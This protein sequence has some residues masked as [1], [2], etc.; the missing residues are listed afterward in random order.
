MRFRVTVDVSV[1]L[2]LDTAVDVSVAI[3]AIGVVVGVVVGAAASAGAAVGAGTGLGPSSWVGFEAWALG[4]A[5][6]PPARRVALD[7]VGELAEIDATHRVALD[8]GSVEG[9]ERPRSNDVLGSHTPMGIEK[10]D[11][12]RCQLGDR[13]QH[14]RQV[15]C[16]ASHPSSPLTNNDPRP[17]QVEVGAAMNEIAMAVTITS[18]S[19]KNR[20]P[21]VCRVAEPPESVAQAK[22]RLRH[23]IWS[24]RSLRPSTERRRMGLAIA[25]LVLRMVADA[26]AGTVA[27]YVATDAEP[28]TTPALDALRRRGSRVLLPVQLPDGDLG[29]GPFDG[30]ESLRAG[31][32][33]I[34][35]P[36]TRLGVVAALS[37][38]VVLVPASAVAG[39]G[40][41]LG[42][43]GGS[44][45]R[46]LARL[47][48]SDRSGIIVCALV[49]DEE[50]MADVPTERHDEPVTRVIT[51]T[52]TARFPITRATSSHPR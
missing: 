2:T 9:W 12:D 40:R 29:W 39:D 13:V 46:V 43:G 51:P 26:Q 20:E 11:V 14:L 52:R 8:V 27:A 42:R 19:R 16:D 5:I 33:G 45:D 35:E 4:L 18:T 21:T 25:Q 23:E 41:R 28:D 48:R 32:H 1:D 47:R 38:D 10:L 6:V 24:A 17:D 37:A 3:G 49:Y 30:W 50:V 31:P 7:V 15:I 44:Y 22:R 36:A 34:L